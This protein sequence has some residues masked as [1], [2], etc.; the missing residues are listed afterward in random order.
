MPGRPSRFGSKAN[1][2]GSNGFCENL[3]LP[4]RLM[5]GHQVLVLSIVVRVHAGQQKTGGF[6]CLE[7]STA[8]RLGLE[9]RSGHTLSRVGR[10]S[11]PSPK[12]C[13]GKLERRRREV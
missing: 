8:L 13:D 10:E 3:I 5:V 9:R 12:A 7:Q 1:R 11:V 4:G 6:L 2:G